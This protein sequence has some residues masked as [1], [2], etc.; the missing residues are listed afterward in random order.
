MASDARQILRFLLLS[1]EKEQRL[2][3]ADRLM[4]GHECGQICIPTSE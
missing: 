2:R 1:A 3:D 4:R